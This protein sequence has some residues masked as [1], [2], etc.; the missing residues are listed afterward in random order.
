[1]GMNLTAHTLEGMLA[2]YF[3]SVITFELHGHPPS[4]RD[5]QCHPVIPG[6]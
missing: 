2:G 3:G 6:T 1:M 4:A 5:K